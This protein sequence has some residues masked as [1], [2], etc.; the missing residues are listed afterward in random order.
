VVFANVPRSHGVKAWAS[1]ART[2]G[3]DGHFRSLPL[4][5]PA[6]PYAPG[7]K[8]NRNARSLSI[9]TAFLLTVEE[10]AIKATHL[11]LRCRPG[12]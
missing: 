1:A 8:M 6:S 5:V 4:G 12:R 10:P 2:A 11:S 3:S 7:R 9:E